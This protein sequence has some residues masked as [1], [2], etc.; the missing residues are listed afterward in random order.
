MRRVLFG[1]TVD[2]GSDRGRT[3]HCA[4]DTLVPRSWINN[5][6]GSLGVRMPVSRAAVRPR[7]GKYAPTRS[8]RVADALWDE[9]KSRASREGHTM[10]H[11]LSL[12]IQGYAAGKIDLPQQILVYPSGNE[13]DVPGPLEDQPADLPP[14]EDESDDLVRVVELEL[15]PARQA[16]PDIFEYAVFKGEVWTDV[17]NVKTLLSHL[18]RELWA[19]DPDRLLSTENGKE[20]VKDAKSPHRRFA[21]ISEGKFLYMHWAT[22]YLLAA[23]RE[24]VTAFELEDHVKVKRLRHPPAGQTF[25]QGRA[26]AQEARTTSPMP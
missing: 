12:L 8:V 11:V 14:L 19:M 6:I 2:L 16:D 15:R 22:H 17:R 23:V 9:A 1:L 10:S 3:P 13:P 25:G 26:E 21:M 7:N 18:A 24:F 20:M 5:G 4:G